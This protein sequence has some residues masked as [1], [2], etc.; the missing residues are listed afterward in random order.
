MYPEAFAFKQLPIEEKKI[1]LDTL[2]A[3][4]QGETQ[5]EEFNKQVSQMPEE[6]PQQQPE[7]QAIVPEQ[8]PTEVAQT[9]NQKID[10]SSKY[11]FLFPQDAAGQAIAQQQ[12]VKRG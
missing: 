3:A 5:D 10:L 7:Q 9:P 11:S 2:K 4:L 12:E 6:Q 8:Q 1:Y